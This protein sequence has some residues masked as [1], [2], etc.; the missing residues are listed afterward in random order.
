MEDMNKVDAINGY[1]KRVASTVRAREADILRGNPDALAALERRSDVEVVT[2]WAWTSAIMG[3]IAAFL[4]APF[5][6]S[7]LN[8]FLPTIIYE[9]L[10]LLLKLGMGCV[11]LMFAAAAWLTFKPISESE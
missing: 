10:W 4:I 2:R 3:A 7:I 11:V 6:L 8:R 9:L 1:I 5:V